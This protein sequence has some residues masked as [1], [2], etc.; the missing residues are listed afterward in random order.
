MEMD[1]SEREGLR[2]DGLS[3]RYKDT[4]RVGVD[5]LSLELPENGLVLLTGPSGC[6]KSTL[7]SL[8][9]SFDSPDRGS[10]FFKG[11]EITSLKGKGLREFRREVLGVCFQE[12]NLLPGLT[13]RENLAPY[14]RRK[15]SE[16]IIQELGLANLLDTPARSLSGGEAE[17]VAVARAILKGSSLIL[18]DEPTASLDGENG[19]QVAKVLKEASRSAL[20]IVA[21]HDISLFEPF[22]DVL[23]RLR[24]GKLVSAERLQEPL[25]YE[26]AESAEPPFDLRREARTLLKD[27]KR[28]LPSHPA[29]LVSGLLLSFLSLAACFS[30][31]SL[32]MRDDGSISKDLALNGS[33]PA[34]LGKKDGLGRLSRTELPEG[35]IPFCSLPLSEPCVLTSYFIDEPSSTRSFERLFGVF[36]DHTIAPYS[37]SAENAF[38]LLAGTAPTSASEALISDTM[39]RQYQAFGFEHGGIRLSPGSFDI[40]GFLAAGPELMLSYPV[41]TSVRI[42]GVFDDGYGDL[43]DAFREQCGDSPIED[44]SSQYWLLQAAGRGAAGAI[45]LSE[46]AF[47]KASEMPDTFWVGNEERTML[48]LWRN[49]DEFI[50]TYVQAYPPADSIF[51]FGVEDGAVLPYDLFLDVYYEVPIGDKGIKDFRSIQ[52]GDSLSDFHEYLPENATIGTLLD[53]S[54]D[55]GDPNAADPA[56]SLLYFAGLYYLDVYGIPDGANV[57]SYLSD[58]TREYPDVDFT[59]DGALEVY[60]VFRMISSYSEYRTI[61][62]DTMIRDFLMDA[63]PV[64]LAVA[65][66]SRGNSNIGWEAFDILAAGYSTNLF[67]YPGVTYVYPGE[68][69]SET[70]WE[71]LSQEDV[72]YF[73]PPEGEKGQLLD[74]GINSHSL[75]AFSPSLASWQGFVRS[76]YGSPGLGVLIG[77]VAAF[78]ALVML[79]SLVSVLSGSNA[80]LASEDALR[81]SLGEGIG[82]PYLRGFLEAS[83]VTLF[84]GIPAL[85]AVAIVFAEMNGVA[86]SVFLNPLSYYSLDVLAVIG[87]FALFL[88][89]S[90]L[91]ALLLLPSGE[92]KRKAALK[93]RFR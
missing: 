61:F 69:A 38:P 78:A 1:I 41:R 55:G 53:E 86:A 19:A 39:F 34:L 81:K 3:L 70:I 11:W 2:A 37:P 16:R 36:L 25:P 31:F 33:D 44:N 8:V 12:A 63:E 75:M 56:G 46:D 64:S 48:S 42:V 43:F 84:G 76:T 85:I 52:I 4:G 47:S 7:L 51:P 66:A 26:D 49:Q 54:S 83:L 88:L 65:P 79:L 13:V 23:V 10:V 50:F 21:S 72:A 28:S 87:A 62:L 74:E 92:K 17:R 32:L 15:D 22:A 29:R 82:R 77:I 91:L 18:V 45:F 58:A 60:W 67:N 27:L 57:S 59:R 30:S 35:S 73:L 20:V 89:L 6:G 68:Q 14:W 71:R 90:A 24:D 9:G 40:A 93:N 5:S 80:L